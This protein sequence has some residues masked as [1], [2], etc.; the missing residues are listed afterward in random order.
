[1]KQQDDAIPE[2][3]L[4]FERNWV[5]LRGHFPGLH[6]E[7]ALFVNAGGSGP[8]GAAVDRVPDLATLL[9]RTAGRR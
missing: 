6:G 9:H 4:T 8:L 5:R 3:L 7:W 2:A 1:M